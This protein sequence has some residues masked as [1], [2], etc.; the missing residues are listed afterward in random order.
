MK[1]VLLFVKLPPPLTGAAF[2]NKVVKDILTSNNNFK[3]NVIP[4]RYL[5]NMSELGDVS[6]KKFFIV[7]KLWFQLIHQLTFNRPNIVYFQ[8]SPLGKAFIR[9]V[10]FFLIIKLFSV[11][12][13]YHIHGKGINRAAQKSFLKRQIYKLTFNNSYVICLS[14]L[15]KEDIKNVYKQKPFILNNGIQSRVRDKTFKKNNEYPNLLFLSNLFYSK[16]I[17]NFLDALE[18]LNNKGL[19]FSAI[20]AGN[21]GNLS[22]TELMKIISAKKL[23]Q[24]VNYIGP[25]YDDAKDKIMGESDI[26]VHPTFDD[27]FPLVL[28]EAMRSKLAIVSTYEGAIPDIVDDGVTGFLVKKNNA[29]ELA[30]KIEVLLKDI[31]LREKMENAGYNK[32]LQKYT[33]QTFENNLMN[34]FNSVLEDC[35]E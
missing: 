31:Q 14:E 18:I 12:I 26:F 13:L 33:L 3:V 2:I 1:K 34:V 7:L 30:D 20:I 17:V 32:Y 16:G 21:E 15:L 22:K 11:K 27:A 23:Q 35:N 4:V 25:V 19:S 24:K 29:T 8:I 5:E 9:D 28:L 6:L 10:L